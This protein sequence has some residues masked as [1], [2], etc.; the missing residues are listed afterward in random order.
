LEPREA[1]DQ[2]MHLQAG[3]D[4]PKFGRTAPVADRWSH[5]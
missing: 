5:Q 4:V 1:V 3:R 2:L